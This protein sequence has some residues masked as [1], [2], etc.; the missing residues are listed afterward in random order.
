MEGRD[1]QIKGNQVQR[2]R[3]IF[4]I[5]SKRLQR[6]KC[7]LKLSVKEGI[8]DQSSCSSAFVLWQAQEGGSGAPPCQGSKYIQ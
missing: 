8:P 1:C 3:I 7:T 6:L 5:N 4:D 2:G